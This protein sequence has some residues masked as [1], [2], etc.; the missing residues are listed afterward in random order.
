METPEAA[1]RSTLSASAVTSGPIPSPPTTASL[2]VREP[3]PEPYWR[4]R[5]AVGCGA[6]WAGPGARAPAVAPPVERDLDGLG[7]GGLLRGR[8]SPGTEGLGRVV[9]LAS[10][11]PGI[12]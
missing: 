3:M 4:G 12:H 8:G 11:I 1:A 2:I 7:R 9:P 6:G 10:R 5:S